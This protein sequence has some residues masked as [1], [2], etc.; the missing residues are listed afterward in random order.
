VLAARLNGRLNSGAVVV[1][2]A[3]AMA[4]DKAL[5]HGFGAF[6]KALCAAQLHSPSSL[7]RRLRYLAC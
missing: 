1:A 2:R 7:R 6:V 5:A 4:A 3:A